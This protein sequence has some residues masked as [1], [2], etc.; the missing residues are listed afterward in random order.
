MVRPPTNEDMHEHDCVR[1]TISFLC[2]LEPPIDG[3]CT[4]LEL[5]SECDLE[6]FGP[7][8]DVTCALDDDEVLMRQDR[9]TRNLAMVVAAVVR[10]SP[11]GPTRR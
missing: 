7:Y 8:V 3:A 11:G 9:Y 2:S 6:V 1:C 10:R 5:C 4:A